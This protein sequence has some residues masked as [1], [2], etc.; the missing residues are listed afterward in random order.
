MIMQIR[1]VSSSRPTKLLRFYCFG[2]FIFASFASVEY[3]PKWWFLKNDMF[4]EK[5]WHSRSLG[6]STSIS[7]A[8]CKTEYAQGEQSS[9]SVW[10]RIAH[11]L[12]LSVFLSDFALIEV[13]AHWL[14][15]DL[16]GPVC[17]YPS[18]HPFF[19]HLSDVGSKWQQ[20]KQGVCV[21][22]CVCVC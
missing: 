17:K 3:E 12:C 8:I 16:E 4:P 11:L 21:C 7:K 10:I 15:C 14:M 9:G 5:G 13:W 19:L 6:S 1:P 2:I 22:V 20:A 18:I